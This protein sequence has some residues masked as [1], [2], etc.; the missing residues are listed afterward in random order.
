MIKLIISTLI[1]NNI[2]FFMILISFK[3]EVFLLLTYFKETMIFK[4]SI[5]LI[6]VIILNEII[7]FDKAFTHS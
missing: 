5:I 1:V 4:K 3:R 7:I 6:K 2:I